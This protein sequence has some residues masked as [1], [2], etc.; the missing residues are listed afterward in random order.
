MSKKEKNQNKTLNK[1]TINEQIDPQAASDNIINGAV[2][3]SDQIEK[4]SMDP[5]INLISP[6]NHDNLKPASYK[7]TIGDE[8][9]I[10]G[11]Y[12]KLTKDDRIVVQPFDVVIIKT[13]EELHMPRDLIARWNIRVT[14]AYE[15][16]LWVGGPQVDPGYEGNLYCP[17]YN[18]SDQEVILEMD[19]SIATIDFIKTTPFSNE[20]ITFN[21]KRGSFKDYNTSLR[22]GLYTNVS[23]RLDKIDAIVGRY[24]SLFFPVIGLLFTLTVINTAVLSMLITSS[25]INNQT[26]PRWMYINLAISILALGVAAF[27]I[28]SGF[29]VF[30]VYTHTKKVEAFPII[31]KAIVFLLLVYL[32][33]EIKFP[34][35][36]RGILGA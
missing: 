28:A 22:S 31:F 5:S 27:S 29:K 18:L 8:Y 10:G 30:K 13:K 34:N 17:I 7:L 14:L 35:F 25:K 23:Q 4:Y 32:F 20:C 15:G 3:L 16:L 26:F 24:T 2:L 6:Y 19:E 11:K 12:R 21:Q 9:S 1:P 36:L 33:I